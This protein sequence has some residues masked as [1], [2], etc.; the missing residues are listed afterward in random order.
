MVMSPARLGTKNDYAGESQ[1]QFTRPTEILGMEIL[2]PIMCW[3]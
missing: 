2:V 1:Q 3:K